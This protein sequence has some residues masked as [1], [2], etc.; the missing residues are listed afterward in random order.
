MKYKIED[1]DF[2]KISPKEFENLCYDILVRYN[3][4]SI[5]WRDGGADNGRDLEAN[6]T[7]STMLHSKETRWFFECKLYNSGGVAVVDLNSK[8]AW[9][10]ADK[11]DFLVFLISSYVTNNTR[12]WLEKIAPDKGYDIVIIEGE[13]LKHRILKFPEL[14]ERYFS[15][16]KYEKLLLNLI[17]YKNKF[18]VSPSFEFLREI[19]DNIETKRLTLDEIGFILLSYFS[20]FI[21]FE[22]R[23][24]Y[25]GDFDGTE[26]NGILDFLK[27]DITD[28]NLESLGKYKDNHIILGDE[29]MFNEFF[30][31][32][33][34]DEID[35]MKQYNFQYSLLH[36]NSKKDKNLWK[37]GEH[38]FIVYTDVAFEIFY[39][40]KIEIR[41]INN[42]V[43][44]NIEGILIEK[45][46][47]VIE[48]YERYLDNFS[49]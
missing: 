31:F 33:Y 13:E 26:M 21:L 16:D 38:L 18:S 1:I 25:S 2:N 8:I 7:F 4:Q 9:A 44:S 30:W 42:F 37:T 10:D 12:T 41:I 45:P 5:S 29:G 32:D 28:T 22:K 11:P 6:Y 20:Q 40:S 19:T 46:A 14:I 36:L 34:P 15:S 39:D 3:Y 17:D 24:E 47:N 27:K 49:A 48:N 43:P 23:Q 35:S